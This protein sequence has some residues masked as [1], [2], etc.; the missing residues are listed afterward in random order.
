MD[1]TAFALTW[2]TRLALLPLTFSRPAPGPVMVVA[3][4]SVRV[5]WPVVRMIVCAR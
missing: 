3:D 4:V 1:A 2:N 5:S